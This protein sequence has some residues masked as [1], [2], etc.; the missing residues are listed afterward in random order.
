MGKKCLVI[1]LVAFISAGCSTSYKKKNRIVEPSISSALKEISRSKI[2][3][4]YISFFKKKP[5]RIDFKNDENFCSLYDLKSGIILISQKLQSSPYAL[6]IEIMKSLVIWKLHNEYKL[7]HLMV[8]EAQ[9]AEIKAI[10]YFFDLGI[11]A[12]DF[13]SDYSFQ[14]FYAP[15]LCRFITINGKIFLNYTQNKYLLNK[16]AC[17]LPLETLNR[18]KTWFS[19]LKE[20]LSD[21]SFIQLM[22]KDDQEKVR[23]GLLSESDAA[24][25]AAILRSK[26]LYEI[27]REQRGYS[28]ISLEKLKKFQ[29]EYE[30]EIKL[31]L[32][33]EKNHYLDIEDARY[34]YNFCADKK[35]ISEIS[36]F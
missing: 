31:F 11:K 21:G 12:E 6:Q 28:E 10:E 17:N 7:D 34:D 14:L 35:F 18:Q 25:N 5:A 33:W 13:N 8:E 27:Y 23:L 3:L 9:L 22:Y 15:A 32:L 26:P 36:I 29:K 20:S 19:K 16:P 24:R 1:F 2:A 4:P 30:K